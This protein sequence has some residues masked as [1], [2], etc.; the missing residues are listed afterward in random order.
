M[1]HITFSR[2]AVAIGLAVLLAAPFAQQALTAPP[3]QMEGPG[4]CGPIPIC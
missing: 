3:P 4:S 1:R 2:I